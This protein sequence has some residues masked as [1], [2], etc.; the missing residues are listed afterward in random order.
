MWVTVT[1]VIFFAGKS[2]LRSLS[3]IPASG[4]AKPPPATLAWC[5]PSTSFGSVRFAV[6]VVASV[7]CTVKHS[8]PSDE[9]ERSSRTAGAPGASHSRGRALPSQSTPE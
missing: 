3:L 1:D 9:G 8:R 2:A 7:A 4:Q 5:A 6:T